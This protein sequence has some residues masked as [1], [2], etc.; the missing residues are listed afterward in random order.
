MKTLIP[1][2]L[3]LLWLGGQCCAAAAGLAQSWGGSQEIRDNDGSGLAFSFNVSDPHTAI[4]D[5]QVTLDISGGL[6]GDLYVYLVHG[7]GFA[8]LLNR[9]GRSSTNLSGYVNPGLQVTLTS[10]ST[11]DIH[12][13]QDSSPVYNGDG[14]LTGSW[15]ADGR[16]L[17]APDWALDTTP[18]TATLAAFNGLNPNGDWTIYFRDASAGG[19]STLKSWSVSITPVQAAP[20]IT[21]QPASQSVALGGPLSLAV[22]VDGVAP[23]HYQWFKNGGMVLDATNSTLAV[24]SAAVTD[25]GVYFV[26]VTNALGMRLSQPVTVTAGAPLLMAWGENNYGQLEDGTTNNQVWP[27]VV[28]S[29]VVA[30]ASARFHSLRVQSDGTLWAAGRN[31]DGQLG[32]GTTVDRTNPVCVASNVVAAAAGSSH[33]LYLKSD[34]GLWA[35]GRNVEGQLGDGANQTR[36]N[37]VLVASNVVVVTAGH[38]HSLFV[39]DDGTLWGMGRNDYYQLGDG[40]QTPRSVPECVASN[41]VA[42]APG[43]LFSRYLQA[44]GTLWGMGQNTAGQLGD[45]SNTPRPRAVCVASNVAAVVAGSAHSLYLTADGVLRGSGFNF[46]GELGDGTANDA[47]SA[48][49]VA[50]NVVALGT[51]EEHSMFV[52]ADGALRATGRNLYGQLGDGSTTQRSSPVSVPGMSVAALLASQGANCGFALGVPL[53]PVIALQP[54]GRATP[55]GSNALFTVTASGFAPWTYQWQFEGADVSG[56]TASN[57]TII[58]VDVTNGGRYAVVISNSVGSVT[59][60]AAVLTVVFTPSITAAP[61]SQT[62]AYGS[63]A[64]FSVT[65]EGTEP[66]SYQWYLGG[67]ALSGATDASY[68]LTAVTGSDQG[69]YRVVVTNPYASATSSVAVLMVNHRPSTV[70][71]V[72]SANPSVF[73]ASM[74]FTATMAPATATGTITFKDDATTLRVASLSGGEAVLDTNGLSGGDHNITAEYSGDS[75]YDPQTSGLLVQTVTRATPLVSPW[76]AASAIAY[77]QT[78]ASSILSGGTASVGG[79][80]AFTEPDTSPGAGAAPQSVTFTPSNPVNYNSVTGSVSV[81]VRWAPSITAAPASQTVAEG[82]TV[83]LSVSAVGA[84]PLSYQWFKDGGLVLGAT[85][86]ALTRVNAGVTNSGVY[87][88]VVTNADGM[89]ISRPASVMVGQPELLAW[90]PNASGQLGDG[91]QVWA[92]LPKPVASNVVAAVAGESHS[93]YVQGDGALWAMGGNDNGQLG[94]GTTATRSNAVSV[95]S[96]VVAVAAGRFHSIY[97]KSDSSAWGMG[98]NGDGQLGDGSF[99][100]RH[101][102]VLAASNVVALAAGADHSLFLMEDGTVWAAGYNGYGQLGDGTTTSRGAPVCVASN[103]VAVAA[104]GLH[105]LFVQ[106]NG[107]LRTVGG[108]SAG[109]LG[110]RTIATRSNAVSVASNVL[111]AVAGYA[112]S[113]YVTRDGALWTVGD[114]SS[115]QLGDGTLVTRSNAAVVASNV[116]VAAGAAFHSHY[117]TADGGLWAMGNNDQGQLGDGTT[118]RRLAPVSVPGMSLARLASSGTGRSTLAVGT[119]LPPVVTSPPTNSTVVAGSAALFTVTATGFAPLSYQWLFEGTNL[120]GATATNHTVSGAMA[121]DAGNYSV[122]VMNDRGSAT[123]AVAV[124]T[125]SKA[126]PNVTVW[127]TASSLV[128]GQTLA[129]STLSGGSASV[130]GSFAFT[131][132]ATAPGAGDAAQSVLFTPADTTNYNTVS[133]TTTVS[134]GKATP[135]VT[136]WPTASSIVFGQALAASTLSGGAASVGGSFAFTTPA[137]APGATA[138]QG[139]VFTPTNTADY[140]TVTGSVSVQVYSVPVITVP[141][142]NQVVSAGGTLSLGVSVEGG[143]PFHYQWFKNGG[144]IPGAT[145]S[146]LEAPGADVTNSGVYFVVITNRAGM[147]ISRPVTVTAGAPELMAWGNNSAGQLGDGTGTNRVWPKSVASNVVAAAAGHFHSLYLKSDGTLWAAGQNTFGQLGDGTTVSRSN[148]VCVA[149]NVVAVSGGDSFSLYLK[150]DGALWGMGRNYEYQLGD[151]TTAV[152]S[153]A[154]FIATNV[155]GLAAG[156]QHSLFVKDDGTLWGMGR[157]WEYELGDG[158]QTTRYVP[159]RLASN[160]VAA[161]AGVSFSMYLQVDGTL[162]GMGQNA[163]GELGDGT[164]VNRTRPVCAASNVLA[165]AAGQNHSMR[166]TADGVLWTVGYNLRGELGDGTTTTASNAIAIASN[167]VAVA[168]GDRHSLFLTGD[169]ALRAMGWNNSGQ[170]GDGTTTQ[171][172]TPVPV[173]GMSLASIISG[174]AADFTLAVG[175]PQAPSITSEPAGQ[176][177]VASSNVTF[178]V[179]ATGFAPMAYQWQVNAT[180]LPGASASNYSILSVMASNAGNY[181]VVVSNACGSVTSSIAVLA[182]T[183]ATPSVTAWGSAT[184]IAFGQTLASSVLSGGSA[185]V[186]G[187]FAFTAPG[188]APAV[189]AAAQSVTFTPVDTTNYNTVSGTVSVTVGKATPNVTLWPVATPISGGQTLAASTLSG[190]SAS[191]GGAF[192]FTT[193]GTVPAGTA[194][195]PVSFTPYNMADYNSVT[196]AVSVIVLAAPVITVPPTNQV[197]AVGAAVQLSVTVTGVPP[198]HY[199]WSKNG[200]FIAGATQSTLTIPSADVTHSGLYG[201]VVTNALGVGISV[202]VTVTVGA[203]QLLAWG[204][205]S[206]GQLGDGTLTNRVWPEVVG[207]NVVAAAAGQLHSLRLQSDGTLWAAGRNAEGQLGDGTLSG[208]S[209][210]VCVASNVVAVSAGSAH[211]L[212]VKSDGTLWAAG[213]N[214]EHELG[215]GTTRTRSNAVCVASNVVGLAAGYQHSLFVKSDGTLWGMGRNYEYELGDGTQIEPLAPERLAS[216]V[217]AAAAGTLHSLYLQTDGTLWGMGGNEQ[218]ALGD[219]TVITRTRPVCVASNVVALAAGG[220][221]SLYLTGDGVLWAAGYNWVGQLGDGTGS[222]QHNAVAVATNVTALAAGENHSLYV[223][224]DGALRAMG[225]NNYG[226]LGDG[227]TTPRLSPVPVSGMSLAAILSGQSASYTLAVGVPLA[228]TFTSQPAAQTAGAGSNVTF[229]VTAQGFAPLTYQW[230]FDGADVSGATSADYV[231]TGASEASAGGYTV[232]VSNSAGSVTSEVAVLTMGITPSITFAPA[233]QAIGAGSNASFSVA[234]AGPGPLSFQWYFNDS[235]LG[236][237]TATNYSLTGVTT[238]DEGNYQVVVI[239]PYGS[240][241]SSPAV[242]TVIR[243]PASVGLASST[244]LAPYSTTVR[245]TAT[246]S[247]GAASGRVTFKDG[248][249]SLGQ[250]DLSEGAAVLDTAALVAGD[251]NITAEY[252]GDATYGPVTSEAL[253]QT[254][255]RAVPVVSAWPEAAMITYGEPL[256]YAGLGGGWGGVD[257][258]FSYLTPAVIPNAGTADQAVIFTPVDGVNYTT[259]TGA[260]SVTVRRATP[261]VTAW[262]AAASIAYG[263]TLAESALSGGSATVDGTFV[264]SAPATRPAAGAA[265]HPVTFIP[266]DTTNYN[267]VNSADSAFLTLRYTGVFGPTT[268]LGGVELGAETPFTLVAVFDRSLNVAPMPPGFGV[269]FFE[270]A[271][272]FEIEGHGTN[273]TAVGS[274]FNVWLINSNESVVPYNG[275]GMGDVAGEYGFF[276]A[277]V[278]TTTPFSGELPTPTEF[279]NFSQVMAPRLPYTVA[280]GDGT[281]N[282]VVNDLGEGAVTAVVTAGGGPPVG[283]EVTVLGAPLIRVS[284]TNQNVVAGGRIDMSVTSFGVGP[285]HYQWFKDGRLVAGETNSLLTIASAGMTNSG[286]YYAVVTNAEGMRISLPATVAAGANLLAW[287]DNSTGQLG[288]GTRNSRSNAVTVA[289]N[290]IAAAAGATHSLFVEADGTLRAMGNNFYGQLGDGTLNLRTNPVAV[291]GGSNVIAVAAG[292]SHSLFLRADGT[293]WAAGWNADGELGDGTG[294]QHNSPVAVV[295]GSNVVAV[296]AGDWHSL[297]LKDDG[298]L[299]A[300]GQNESGQ[301]GDGSTDPRLAPVCVASNVVAVASGASH[302]LFLTV[303]GALWA[304]GANNAGQLGDGTTTSQHRPAAVPGATAVV[305]IAAGASHSLFL[306]AD[307]A[308]W[309]MG[310]NNGGQLGDGTTAPRQSPVPVAWGSNVVSVAAGAAHSL[311]LKPGGALWASGSNNRGQLGDGTTTPRTTPAPVTGMYLA[312]VVSGESA[313]HTLAL[314][315][316][317]A[318]GPVF[319]SFPANV[320]LAA[321]SWDKTGPSYT[322]A[323]TATDSCGG[324]VT[325]RYTD[326]GLCVDNTITRS[327]TAS[328]ACGN[329]T[330]SNQ[331]LALTGFT[332]STAAYSVNMETRTATMTFINPHGLVTLQAIT[333][334]NALMLGTA[335]DADGAV[336][337][338]NIPVTVDA[339]ADLP[340]GTV[341]VVIFV[342]KVDSG[343]PAIFNVM[344]K[345]TGDLGVSFD[346]VETV[347]AATGGAPVRQTFAGLPAAEHFIRVAN[348]SPGLAWMRVLVNGVEYRLDG[349]SAGET[350]VLDAASA[351]VEGDN[352]VVTL[353]GQGAAGAGALVLVGD[354][355]RLAPGEVLLTAEGQDPADRQAPYSIQRGAAAGIPAANGVDVSVFENTQPIVTTNRVLALPYPSGIRVTGVNGPVQWIRVSLAGL[356]HACP[357]DLSVLLAGPGGRKV[358]LMSGAGAGPTLWTA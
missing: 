177:V 187:S 281:S 156:Y 25:S 323:P 350:R 345:D 224:G 267:S 234:A 352:N 288:D 29:N 12:N 255:Y 93:L 215:D 15:A 182:V 305:A 173:P 162:W 157:N 320:A 132:P 314:G 178:T 226:Q 210:A 17:P 152:R 201:V 236:G 250:S 79:T 228:P 139:V 248:V 354:A 333:N 88:V 275:A 72:S 346:P 280:I 32:D 337:S 295:N 239:N 114:N 212:Y 303:D 243:R 313:T 59:S 27:I 261:R 13:Y 35:M 237:A 247:P 48:I 306:K 84:A 120:P 60:S 75:T 300:T 122:V 188:T 175:A 292:A 342:S 241:T 26:A 330:T 334:R 148:A 249:D 221:H 101:A 336:L 163:E 331:I 16:D 216:N 149:S 299:W 150:S 151:G 7:D 87:Y 271:G 269:G 23:F 339:R 252:S 316:A 202:P 324:T 171:R 222:D 262:P 153:N 341:K 144:A 298:T 80:F 233:S 18:R 5:I 131:T 170:L 185:S 37:A 282:L 192:A 129:S 130:S 147:R 67:V 225:R 285:F 96:G 344:A 197:V 83:S 8:V 141:P 329:T 293:L 24:A 194:S 90:G 56:A 140:T 71:L 138:L 117:L 294:V 203:P 260:V 254:V 113:L 227:T 100:E 263:Q 126:T 309:A 112:H 217:V 55:V 1:R 193:P 230:R 51:G 92:P 85:N 86:S 240:V 82:G 127:P 206:Y 349:L 357:A 102:A 41:V 347:L 108:N 198:F 168:A 30:V 33:S 220:N 214:V 109:Q 97:L 317:S 34:G 125:V 106:R 270:A 308:M 39:K 154:V 50:T 191:V 89:R 161:A 276:A 307:G 196:G 277:F 229:S 356:V 65:A 213:R 43:T 174:E 290:V 315:V 94:D 289:T 326:S 57:Y 238:N 251:H 146:A 155:A 256:E 2:L 301:L 22:S 98:F 207:S 95:G 218:G 283:A 119:P 46:F 340:G 135:D 52:T 81:M 47:L 107:V 121:A 321:G 103:A 166:L 204:A 242:L 66:L 6:N 28:A 304:M 302:S 199:Q 328:D 311:F 40:T 49:T 136:V 45:G 169:G 284:P 176:T 105:S 355:A 312:S 110:D 278:E 91:T 205:N 343:Q 70:G 231:L 268:T 4:A 10:G 353:I 274:G 195:Q 133:G 118:T 296:A 183:K 190:G 38:Q 189:G 310:A 73:G 180:N 318:A 358:A 325:I 69:N 297:F 165:A 235:L 245:F 186:A 77:G 58:G 208:R 76:P 54:A 21:G 68:S 164:L 61:A 137:A 42:A 286:V 265:V 246:V 78:L 134:V 115:G 322:G 172:T 143:A 74:R 259:V 142:S 64:S 116:V 124:L 258:N 167:V 128:F 264:F 232:V 3:F 181:T 219:G 36:S 184:A 99:T 244:N 111:A 63:N 44:D 266:I 287:G 9:P 14:Q 335:Y 211:S 272:V 253:I 62:I 158:T 338:N 19:V 104:G 327:W 223:A 291:Q 332:G 53:A 31:D 145:N 159:A 179:T 20:V 351:T 11:P 200:G 319:A 257:G 209:N 160:V 279:T 348:G 273:Y 123:S